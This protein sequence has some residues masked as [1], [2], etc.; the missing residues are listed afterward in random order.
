MAP[1]RFHAGADFLVVG[2]PVWK[3]SEPMRAVRDIVDQID[4][5]LSQRSSERQRSQSPAPSL[6]MSTEV[7]LNLRREAGAATPQAYPTRSEA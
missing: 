7:L 5:G 3:A 2:S 4:Q 1:V 6:E